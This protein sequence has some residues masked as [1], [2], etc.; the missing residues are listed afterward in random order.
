LLAKAFAV[1]LVG[2]TLILLLLQI[3]SQW[4]AVLRARLSA[5]TSGHRARDAAARARRSRDRGPLELRTRWRG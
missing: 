4:F 3:S 1:A 5:A 2:Y